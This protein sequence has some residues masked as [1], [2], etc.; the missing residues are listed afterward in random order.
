MSK[1]TITRPDIKPDIEIG[2]EP[3][4][5]EKRCICQLEVPGVGRLRTGE[6]HPNFHL[7]IRQ[8]NI[9]PEDSKA[10]M[11]KPVDKI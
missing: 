5:P 10:G 9:K 4:R 1:L 3:E 6:R 8:E 2:N 11:K 7:D